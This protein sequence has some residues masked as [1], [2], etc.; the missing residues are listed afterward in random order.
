MLGDLW[1]HPNS[2][3]LAVLKAFGAFSYFE[4]KANQSQ[5][6][7]SSKRSI[8]ALDVSDAESEIVSFCNQFNVHHVCSVIST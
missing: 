1:F 7:I 2:D 8:D 3:I 6:T 4:A 5:S